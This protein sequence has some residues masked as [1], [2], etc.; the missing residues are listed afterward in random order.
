[1]NEIVE[2]KECLLCGL[3]HSN[4]YKTCNNCLEYTRGQQRKHYEKNKALGLCVKCG[5]TIT[6]GTLCLCC[7]QKNI[8]RK[9]Y[10][11]KKRKQ[12]NK[13]LCCGVDLL[14]LKNF[15]TT[16]R[17]KEKLKNKKTGQRIKQNKDKYIKKINMERIKRAERFAE[18][19]CSICGKNSIKENCKHCDGC[20]KLAVNKS[21]EKR[22]RNF[23]LGLC[24]CSN[25]LH[26]SLKTCL[27]CWFK[28]MAFDSTGDIKNAEA[29]RVLLENQGYKCFYTDKLLI[30]GDNASLDHIVPTS[31]N[32]KYSLENVRWVDFGI[33][34]MKTNMTH[35]E[36]IETC[37]VISEKFLKEKVGA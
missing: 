36:F 18:G 21:R 24:K 13:C 3:Q 16:C 37:R 23:K 7:Y 2:I 6:K 22:V 31:R 8:S 19:L 12:E 30:I 25:P 11:H 5:V 32:G 29:L 20:L 33:N 1:M 15:C 27:S 9:V 10:T 34:S 17:E 14:N 35:E 26:G 28:R 4:R